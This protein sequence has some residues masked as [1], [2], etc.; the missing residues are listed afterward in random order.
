MFL[1]YFS[2]R[3]MEIVSL[4]WPRSSSSEPPT[5]ARLNYL[6][7]PKSFDDGPLETL[8]E[9][10]MV[11]VRRDSDDWWLLWDWCAHSFAK[12]DT[13]G[14]KVSFQLRQNDIVHIQVI[15]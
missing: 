6:Y 13:P 4:S 8:M 3:I 12:V 5:I 11:S 1:A 15:V 7:I 10:N 14:F 9:C 2:S